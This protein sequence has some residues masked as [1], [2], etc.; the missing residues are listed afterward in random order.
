MN[1][2]TV[3]WVGGG[4]SGHIY[5]LEWKRVRKIKTPALTRRTTEGRTPAAW[6]QQSKHKLLHR[7]RDLL[8][9]NAR[10]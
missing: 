9:T 8:H 5:I 1:R 10:R 7:N 2:F 4:S 6:L 3:E